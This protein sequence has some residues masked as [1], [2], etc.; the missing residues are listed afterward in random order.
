MDI[1]WDDARLFLA[2]AEA[3]S[4]SGAARRLRI[5]QPTVSRRLAELE[6]H[7]GEPLFARA[8]GGATPTPYGERLLEPARRMAEWAAELERAAAGAEGKPRG[9]VRVT[10]PPGIAYDFLVPFAAELRSDLPEVRFEVLSSIRHL[11]LARGEADLALRMMRPAQ[12]ELEHV[13][14]VALTP[15]AFASPAYAA[16]LPP[17]PKLSDLDWVGWAPPL[18]QTPPN[19]NLARLIPDWTPAFTSDD[20]LIQHRAAELGLGAIILAH[21]RHRFRRESTL[22]PLDVPVPPIKTGLHLVGVRSALAIP[23][24]RAVADRLAAELARW[25]T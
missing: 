11:D 24:V 15:A 4:L 8:A 20:F 6:A 12:R 7:L 19:P 14:S 1:S 22:V 9:L 16:K 2:I 10:A 5:A 21:A 17:N 3:G 13:A 23:R 18:D 25:E